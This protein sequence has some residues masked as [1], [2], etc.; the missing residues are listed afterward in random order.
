MLIDPHPT[1]QQTGPENVVLGLQHELTRK[2]Q[3]LNLLCLG[4]LGLMGRY[5]VV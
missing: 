3:E 1:Q 4:S 2:K 5:I